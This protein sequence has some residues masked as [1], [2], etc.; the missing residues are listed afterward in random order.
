MLQAV[1]STS[2]GF[3]KLISCLWGNVSI[4]LSLS[5]LAEKFM[6]TLVWK[7]GV[8]GV[9]VWGSVLRCV[10]QCMGAGR[11][12]LVLELSLQG[13]WALGLSLKILH[14]VLEINDYFLPNQNV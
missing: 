1:A 14:Y 6:D 10:Q 5:S 12:P 13:L 3:L 2:E 11:Q 7:P 9:R 8:S 4:A